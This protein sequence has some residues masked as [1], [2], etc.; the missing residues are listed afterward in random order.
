MA[1]WVA[2]S[3]KPC[4]GQVDWREQVRMVAGSFWRLPQL[5]WHLVGHIIDRSSP[6]NLICPAIPPHK[7]DLFS[8][9]SDGFC[10]ILQ[11]TK[12]GLPRLFGQK[13]IETAGGEPP[14]QSWRPSK[15]SR[16]HSE[17]RPTSG[18]CTKF[19]PRSSEFRDDDISTPLTFYLSSC[20]CEPTIRVVSLQTWKQ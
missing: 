1:G 9:T 5:R 16:L 2:G 4:S 10:S 18:P 12:A 20:E 11:A 7:F 8:H 17:N 15:H 14:A 19:F 3:Q 6:L 13:S